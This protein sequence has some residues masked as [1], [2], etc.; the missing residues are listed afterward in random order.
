VHKNQLVLISK[1]ILGQDRFKN[2]SRVYYKGADG[3]IICFD[4][5]APFKLDSLLQWRDSVHQVL[6]DKVPIVL[7]ANKV[8]T[9]FLI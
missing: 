6:G 2:L 1:L 4:S 3:V 7:S 9:F 5:A 8:D